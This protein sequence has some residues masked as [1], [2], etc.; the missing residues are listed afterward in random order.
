MAS[1]GEVDLYG[2]SE[3]LRLF[4]LFLRLPFEASSDVDLI[5]RYP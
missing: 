1:D 2:M 5:L 4:L 3:L